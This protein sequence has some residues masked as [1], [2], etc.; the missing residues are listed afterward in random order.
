MRST[1]VQYTMLLI[2]LLI[3]VTHMVFEIVNK[4]LECSRCFDFHMF[5]YS[6]PY[7]FYRCRQGPRLYYIYPVFLCAVTL[8]KHSSEIVA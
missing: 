7:S 5:E 2:F 6:N 4:H 3:Y 8:E 1:S